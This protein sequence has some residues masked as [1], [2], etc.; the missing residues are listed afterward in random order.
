MPYLN[1]CQEILRS[2]SLFTKYYHLA[3]QWLPLDSRGYGRHFKLLRASFIPLPPLAEQHR[4]VAKVDKLM[5]L[6][7]R[8]EAA[9]AEREPKR[10]RL[11]SSSLARLRHR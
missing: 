7:G 4:I 2:P 1:D 11:A 10:D 8:L 9:R 6:C 5:A 3:M